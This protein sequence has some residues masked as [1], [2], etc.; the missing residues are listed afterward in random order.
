VQRESRAAIINGKAATSNLHRN[1]KTETTH[2]DA[3]QNDGAAN[4]SKKIIIDF[5]SYLN[6]LNTEMRFSKYMKT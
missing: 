4:I 1:N 3:A 2:S 6:T 5:P